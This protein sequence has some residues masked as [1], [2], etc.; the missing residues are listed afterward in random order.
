MGGRAYLSFDPPYPNIVRS[1]PTRNAKELGKI[2]P[3]EEVEILDGPQCANKMVWWLVRSLKT[4]LTGWTSE[5]DS[6]KYWL[7]PMD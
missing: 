2:Y 6:E 5:G 4:G 3:G 1:Q 7:V